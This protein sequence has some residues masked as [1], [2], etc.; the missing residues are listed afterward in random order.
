MSTVESS[1]RTEGHGQGDVLGPDHPHRRVTR[2]PHGGRLL[3][4]AGPEVLLDLDGVP[5]VRHLHEGDRPARRA[6]HHEPHLRHLRRQ[7]L[8]L[9]LPEPEHG[10][11]GQAA[12]AR[13]H[14]LQHGR[15][16]GLHLR[17]RDLQR[18][19]GERGLLRADG[20]GD[21]PDAAREGREHLR[22]G[23]GHPRL[24]D[25][26][27]HHA[28]AQPVHGRVLPGDPPRG[29]LHARDVLPVRRPAHAPV[30]DHAGRLQRRHHPPDVHGVLR[31]PHEVLRLREEK[32]AD[33]RRPVRL[34][35]H[36]APR[37]RHGRLPGDEPRQLGLVRRSG[38]RRL[39][40]PRT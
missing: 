27:R 32:R 20:E 18:L 16:R 34:L 12:A 22:A 1:Q 30:D 13:R 5:R 29:P 19:H 4:P 31:A 28:G 38:L 11:R 17:P 10:L 23:A 37:L 33:A 6:L 25:D 15:G 36:G 8:H 26:R 35:P 2:D 7:P 21:E 3:Q 24:Q 14:G 39:L 9:L 40:V